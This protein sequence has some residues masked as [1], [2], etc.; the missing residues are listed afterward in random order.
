MERLSRKKIAPKTLFWCDLGCTPYPETH[1]LQQHLREQI[2]NGHG[3]EILLVTE[4]PPTYTLGSRGEQGHLRASIQELEQRGF[5]VFATER[6]G[7]VTY[8]GPGQLVL[9]PI[10]DLS[11]RNFGVRA[12]VE[13]LEEVMIQLAASY[14]LYAERKSGYPGVW[15]GDQKIGAIG[16]HVRHFVTIH[17]CAFNVSPDLSHFEGIIPCGIE[18]LGVTSLEKQTKNIPL[19]NDIVATAVKIFASVFQISMVQ[20]HSLMNKPR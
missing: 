3:A 14:G 19:R 10:L 5:G 8:H 6:G 18:H 11:C 15:I 16:I 13:R 9:Y 1:Q 4:H 12:Y 17:G 20:T 7:S 2:L